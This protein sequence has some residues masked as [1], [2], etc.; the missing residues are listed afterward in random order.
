M[1]YAS[2]YLPLLI[3]NSIS[4]F[5]GGLV[6]DLLRSDGIRHR[7]L[8][9]A[10]CFLRLP[11]NMTLAGIYQPRLSPPRQ[12]PT[13][14]A[15]LKESRLQLMEDVEDPLDKYLVRN[16]SLP[17]KSPVNLTLLQFF[18]LIEALFV[19]SAEGEPPAPAGQPPSGTGERQSRPEADFQQGGPEERS[20]QGE[21]R[22]GSA[23]FNG[24]F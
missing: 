10:D 21:S 8:L 11:Q 4:V 15:K 7:D 14:K 22:P 3:P 12:V 13:K 5:W 24:A 9:G 19:C 17:S 23:R 20:G 16:L 2:S 6:L 1:C 18:I